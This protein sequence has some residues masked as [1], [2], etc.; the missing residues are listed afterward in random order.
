MRR[1][2]GSIELTPKRVKDR[3]REREREGESGKK[4]ELTI[5]FKR[6]EKNLHYKKYCNFK[7]NLKNRLFLCS[8][9]TNLKI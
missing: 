5:S 2:W 3:I 4:R 6:R 7:V 9:L 8:L 1:V